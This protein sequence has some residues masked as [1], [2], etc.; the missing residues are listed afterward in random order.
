MD[1]IKAYDRVNRNV[2]LQ[3][4]SR[5]GCGEKFL[6]GLGHGLND[7]FGDIG[8][9][10][11]MYTNGVKQGSAVSCRLYTYYLDHALRAVNT[12]RGWLLR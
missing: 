1:Y 6:H 3:M 10:K 4:L 7:N 5:N 11:F 12:Y 9:E 8:K 2:L